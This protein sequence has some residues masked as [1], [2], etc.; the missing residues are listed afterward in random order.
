MPS[1]TTAAVLSSLEALS[2]RP[3]LALD[4]VTVCSQSGPFEPVAL[5]GNFT[6]PKQSG[7]VKLPSELMGIVIVKGHHGVNQP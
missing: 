1:I 3:R 6:I 4:M 5:L 2:S 7:T